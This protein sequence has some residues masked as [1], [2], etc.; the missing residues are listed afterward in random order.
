MVR[1]DNNKIS[2]I[3]IPGFLV[4]LF[5]LYLTIGTKIIDKYKAVSEYKIVL[6]VEPHIKYLSRRGTGFGIWEAWLYANSPKMDTIILNK[7]LTNYFSK[8][9]LNNITSLEEGDQVVLSIVTKSKNDKYI[10][11]TG[12]KT[13]NFNYRSE[14]RMK[15]MD[16]Y[17]L[18]ISI[19]LILGPFYDVITNVIFRIFKIKA[20]SYNDQ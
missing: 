20:K 3:H 7:N 11:A 18:A 14:V 10:T 9:E 13:S 8:K 19:L 2:R 1:K 6:S 15:F 16:Y 12:I 17:M 5:F 4:G